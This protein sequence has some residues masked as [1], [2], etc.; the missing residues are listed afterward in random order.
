MNDRTHICDSL[1]A[2]N[3]APGMYLVRNEII[4]LRV[5]VTLGRVELYPFSAGTHRRLANEARPIEPRLSSQVRLTTTIRAF[6]IRACTV[7]TRSRVRFL[8]FVREHKY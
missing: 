5:A 7:H 6:D 8:R 4:A 2:S 1:D 3:L